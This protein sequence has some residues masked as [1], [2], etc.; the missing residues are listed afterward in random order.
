MRERKVD[1]LNAVGV[2]LALR[3]IVE[4]AHTVVG[5]HAEF[6]FQRLDEGVEQIEH[7][8]FAIRLDD[9]LHLGIDQ[10]DEDHGAAALDVARVVDLAHHL[11]GLVGGVDEGPAHM[12]RADRK[13]VEDGVAEGFGGDARAVGDEEDCAVG[14]VAQGQAISQVDDREFA[15]KLDF[16]ITER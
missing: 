10:R 3:H 4:A 16:L 13:L 11:M 5:G 9:G 8:A 12:V 7:Q 6:G 2:L 15:R 14:H 1:G